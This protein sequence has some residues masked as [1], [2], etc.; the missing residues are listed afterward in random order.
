MR[1]R[2]SVG[3]DILRLIP[4]GGAEMDMAKYPGRAVAAVNAWFLYRSE[5]VFNP[6]IE[7]YRV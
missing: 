1:F 5:G 4:L 3:V 6:D 2:P 7:T